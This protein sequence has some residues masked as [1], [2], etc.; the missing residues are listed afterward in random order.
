MSWKCESEIQLVQINREMFQKIKIETIKE[1]LNWKW[2]GKQYPDSAQIS[3]V[4]KALREQESTTLKRDYWTVKCVAGSNGR[5]SPLRY[6]G[7]HLLP[8]RGGTARSLLLPCFWTLTYQLMG[9]EDDEG[10]RGTNCFG[11]K[12]LSLCLKAGRGCVCNAAF[13]RSRE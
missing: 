3:V 6:G 4:P 10:E 7:G 8:I 12:T 11:Q 2:Q 9:T 13:N 5:V 1:Q